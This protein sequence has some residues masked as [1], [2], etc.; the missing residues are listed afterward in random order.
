MFLTR[1]S[2]GE[3]A[4]SAEASYFNRHPWLLV[5]YLLTVTLA[6]FF[7]PD[8]WKPV[9]VPALIVLQIAVLAWN[10]QA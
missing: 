4:M 3:R 2:N 5:V 6:A 9:V 8:A 1:R 7:T 10:R